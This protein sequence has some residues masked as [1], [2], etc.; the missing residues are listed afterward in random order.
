MDNNGFGSDSE[1]AATLK[2]YPG[3]LSRVAESLGMSPGTVSRTFHG[4]T[5]EL[6]PRIV[7]AIK[8]AIAQAPKKR[9]R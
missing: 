1:R 8:E 6:N 3:I 4:I 5:R 9:K 7:E 2:A